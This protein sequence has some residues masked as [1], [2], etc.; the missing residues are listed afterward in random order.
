[1]VSI[2]EFVCYYSWVGWL[3]RCRP[4]R[5]TWCS[6]SEQWRS[7]SRRSGSK[8][9]WTRLLMVRWRTRTRMPL[10]WS[11]TSRPRDIG[12]IIVSVVGGSMLLYIYAACVAIHSRISLPAR[13]GSSRCWGQ[14]MSLNKHKRRSMWSIIYSRWSVQ[15]LNMHVSMYQTLYFDGISQ[16]MNYGYY[17]ARSCVQH[18][19]FMNHS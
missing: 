4:I 10:P 1:M 19:S 3:G 11:M 7:C 2:C 18:A 17:F 15:I 5:T 13:L 14:N 9:P 8:R 16:L 12:V 6:V